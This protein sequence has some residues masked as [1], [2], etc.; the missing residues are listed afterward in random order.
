M[1]SGSALSPYSQALAVGESAGQRYAEFSAGL[2]PEAQFPSEDT[3]ADGKPN[4]IE[5][6]YGT[7]P[8][9]PDADPERELTI[10]ATLTGEIQV[11]F[12]HLSES[13]YE[14]DILMSSELDRWHPLL[15]G[16]DYQIVSSE[17]WTAPGSSDSLTRITLKLMG[18][19]SRNLAD[20]GDQLFMRLAVSPAAD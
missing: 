20:S 9:Q 15:R 12:S 10:S 4:L 14:W 13:I 6:F 17:N 3:D 5:H 2:G 7:N 19:S 1:R 18:Q 11:V 8:L 16:V